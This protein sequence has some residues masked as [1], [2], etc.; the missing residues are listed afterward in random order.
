MRVHLVAG[1]PDADVGE[2]DE[3]RANYGRT[4]S[5]PADPVSNVKEPS[6]R[7]MMDVPKTGLTAG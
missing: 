3:I 2:P 1:E 4:V 7:D 5:I 6:S